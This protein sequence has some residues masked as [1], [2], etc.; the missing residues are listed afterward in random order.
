VGLVAGTVDMYKVRLIAKG[1]KKRHGID[2]EDTFIPAVNASTI[3]I[4]LYISVS[5][6][7]SLWLL[8]AN[9]VFLH[10]V[11]EGEIYMNTP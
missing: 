5:R 2:F 1:F 9:N 11:L 7:W 10:G 6:G 4:V 8:Y 3:K